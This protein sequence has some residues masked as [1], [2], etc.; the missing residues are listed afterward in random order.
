MF[1]TLDT[2]FVFL[3]IVMIG[4]MTLEQEHAAVVLR[5]KSWLT[6]K[7]E[8]VPALEQYL[9]NWSEWDPWP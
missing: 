9:E 3:R 1:D 7:T 2:Y 5:V 4:E 6:A 8:E